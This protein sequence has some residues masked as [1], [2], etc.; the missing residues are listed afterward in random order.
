M[1]I[2]SKVL[3][4]THFQ[5]LTVFFPPIT[6]VSMNYF[7]KKTKQLKNMDFKI[8]FFSPLVTT[9]HKKDTEIDALFIFPFR[10]GEAKT[11]LPTHQMT[12]MTPRL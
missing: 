6:S 1:W 4:F 12:N 9:S 5:L 3:H 11:R 7:L 2:L 8:F 10:L